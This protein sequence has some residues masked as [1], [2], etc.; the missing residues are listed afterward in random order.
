MS[1]SGPVLESVTRRHFVSHEIV[2]LL[3]VVPEAA[4]GVQSKMDAFTHKGGNRK[5][6]KL[7]E[8]SFVYGHFPGAQQYPQ[9]RLF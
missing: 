2:S 5:S 6:E 1:S 7:A 3:F 4:N 9:S 8:V